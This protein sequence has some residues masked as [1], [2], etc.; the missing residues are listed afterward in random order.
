MLVMSL[1]RRAAA[2][3]LIVFSTGVIVFASGLAAW[4]WLAFGPGPG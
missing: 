2:V 4:I 3:A 1:M